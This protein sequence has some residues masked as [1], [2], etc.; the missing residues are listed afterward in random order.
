MFRRKKYA[1]QE[2]NPLMQWMHDVFADTEVRGAAELKRHHAEEHL[3]YFKDALIMPI[4]APRHVEGRMLESHVDRMLLALSAIESGKSLFEIEEFAEKKELKVDYQHTAETLLEHTATVSAA[5][6]YIVACHYGPIRFHASSISKGAK[7]GLFQHAYSKDHASVQDIALYQKLV[8]GMEASVGESSE[9]EVMA[10]MYEQYGVLIEY[11]GISQRIR[12]QFAESASFFDDERLSERSKVLALW[13]A[14]NH[15]LALSYLKNN[16]ESLIPVLTARAH[17]DGLDA[18][19]A[20]DLMGALILV[21]DVFGRLEYQDGRIISPMYLLERLYAFENDILERKKEKLE[22]AAQR[23]R[24]RVK[25]MLEAEGLT[26]KGILES[27]DIARRDRAE[28]AQEIYD[29]VLYGG[30]FHYVHDE[31]I[32]A[33]LLRLHDRFDHS[34]NN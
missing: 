4:T 33:V 12:L 24:K 16:T 29:I 19:D 21:K 6:L 13:L 14:K 28:A 3:P 10:R 30:D 34:P 15:S 22:L 17:E 7:E 27:L 18:K 2:V 23:T 31:E 9:G 20:I 32:R 26:V 1:K 8:K 5:A 11:V 25:T